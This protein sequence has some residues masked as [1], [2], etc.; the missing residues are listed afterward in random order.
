MQ[1]QNSDCGSNDLK[2]LPY[3]DMDQMGDQPPTSLVVPVECRDCG[4][5][6]ELIYEYNDI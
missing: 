6:F 3:P 2:P 1:C 5:N 4:G